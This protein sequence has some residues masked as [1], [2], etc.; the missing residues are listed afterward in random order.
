M[1][2]WRFFYSSSISPKCI[3][4][5]GDVICFRIGGYYNT[6]NLSFGLAVQDETEFVVNGGAGTKVG[7]ILPNFKGKKFWLW[8]DIPDGDYKY[9]SSQIVHGPSP[10]PSPI[11]SPTKKVPV[12]SYKP[13]EGCLAWGVNISPETGSSMEKL[14]EGWVFYEYPPPNF[15]L[16]KEDVYAAKKGVDPNNGD[17]FGNNDFRISSY[18]GMAIGKT[19]TWKNGDEA[20]TVWRKMEVAMAGVEFAPTSEDIFPGISPKK[21][22]IPHPCYEVGDDF[23]LQEGDRVSFGASYPSDIGIQTWKGALETKTGF[24]VQKLGESIAIAC[25]PSWRSNGFVIWRLELQPPRWYDYP[26]AFKRGR[27]QGNA[28]Y[29]ERLP[30]P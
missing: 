3:L 13:I 11:P 6:T 26:K 19:A 1:S 12:D 7:A 14:V 2:N 24:T 10:I 29:S 4:K 20:V 25:F 22:W 28:I 30:L 15:I 21:N 16:A 8:R 27:F 23:I 18:H 17:S 9:E 5:Y